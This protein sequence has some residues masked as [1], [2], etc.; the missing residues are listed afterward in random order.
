MSLRTGKYFERDPPRTGRGWRHGAR[1]LRCFVPMM[2][3]RKYISR[4]PKHPHNALPN[5]PYQCS[6]QASTHAYHKL[7]R[8]NTGN[9]IIL[10]SCYLFKLSNV[11]AFKLADKPHCPTSNVSC[12][13]L[14]SLNQGN[15]ASC[16]LSNVQR[17]NM[18]QIGG[19]GNLKNLKL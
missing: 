14:E 10:Q 15:I 7:S 5:Y 16:H 12:S 18:L 9:C 6:P 3:Y 8:Y 17:L 13:C 19:V 2:Y 4:S 11:H 1:P